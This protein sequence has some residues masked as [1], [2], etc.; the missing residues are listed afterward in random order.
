MAAC[1]VLILCAVNGSP[2]AGDQQVARP[3]LTHKFKFYVEECSVAL[4]GYDTRSADSSQTGVAE[5]ER[6]YRR[7]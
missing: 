7:S 5:T 1:G 4:T 3:L 2:W 6:P